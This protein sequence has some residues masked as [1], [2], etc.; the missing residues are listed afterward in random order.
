MKILNAF[1]RIGCLLTIL[2][3]VSTSIGAQTITE[4]FDKKDTSALYLGIDFTRSKLIN[5]PNVNVNVLRDH[6]FTKI[7]EIIVSEPKKYDLKKL[8]HKEHIDHDLG[9]VN[10]KNQ[11]MNVDGIMSTNAADIH[12]LIQEDIES[13]VKNY[14]FGDK[15][16]LGL[17][18]VMEGLDKY[19]KLISM[20]VNVVDMSTKEVLMNERIDGEVSMGF[21]VPNYYASGIK[22]MMNL[23]QS[24]FYTTWKMKFGSDK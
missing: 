4:F 3:S 20:W 24:D 21:G 5:D 22:N 18:F 8:F 1:V 2:F 19:R 13:M 6:D 17:L 14:D 11:A 9:F 10:A 23:I 7:N 16:G 15:R 12:H